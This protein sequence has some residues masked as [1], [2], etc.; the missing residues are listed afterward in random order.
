MIVSSYLGQSFFFFEIMCT[1]DLGRKMSRK[2][3]DW[4]VTSC[5]RNAYTAKKS[6]NLVSVI[7]PSR[8]FLITYLVPLLGKDLPPKIIHPLVFGLYFGQYKQSLNK[9][10][11]ITFFYISEFPV[12]G[13]LLKFALDRFSIS[14]LYKYLRAVIYCLAINRSEVVY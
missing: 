14:N 7:D 4:L 12:G 5:L 9:T 11:R 2:S 13:I 3:A 6:S 8:F 1:I 10:R